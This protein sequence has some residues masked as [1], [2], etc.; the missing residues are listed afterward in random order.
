MIEEMFNCLHNNSVD[1]PFY[2]LYP[3]HVSS[4]IKVSSKDTQHFNVSIFRL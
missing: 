1:L 2:L 4:I 3:Y